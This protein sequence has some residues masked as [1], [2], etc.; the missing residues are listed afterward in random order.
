MGRYEG[1]DDED[2]VRGG[3]DGRYRGRGA[4]VERRSKLVMTR[5]QSTR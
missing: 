1:D 3:A 2:A 4:G 5:A